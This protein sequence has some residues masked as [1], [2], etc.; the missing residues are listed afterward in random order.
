MMCLD[1]L[2]RK[3]DNDSARRLLMGVVFLAGLWVVRSRRIPMAAMAWILT[4]GVA[5]NLIGAGLRQS[6][7]IHR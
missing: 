3:F 4:L 5:L 1:S 6:D 2:Q 7:D